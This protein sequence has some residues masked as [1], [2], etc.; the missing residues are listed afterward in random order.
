MTANVLLR[1][2]FIL[3]VKLNAAIYFHTSSYLEIAP[4][5]EAKDFGLTMAYHSNQSLVVGAPYSDRNGKVYTCPINDEVL[6]NRKAMCT[7]I[8][9]DIDKEVPDHS[10]S[11]RHEQSY[12]LGASIAVTPDYIFTCA[13]LLT[14][15]IKT[16]DGPLF[17]PFGTCFIFNGT[18]TSRYSSDKRLL[19]GTVGWRTLA[20]VDNRLILIAKQNGP[21]SDIHYIFMDKPSEGVKIVQETTTSDNRKQYNSFINKGTAFA[22][23]NFI[24][25]YPKL[26]AFSAAE[27]KNYQ[28]LIAFLWYNVAAKKLEL[29]KSDQRDIALILHDKVDA[30]FGSSLH[31][32]NVNADNYTDLLVGAPAHV[33]NTGGYENGAIYIYLGGETHVKSHLILTKLCIYSTKDGSRFG[34]SIATT[35][36][37]GDSYP[38]IFVSAPFEDNGKGTVYIISGHTVHNLLK[39][40]ETEVHLTELVYTQKIQNSNLQSLGYSLQPL[41]VPQFDEYG[42]YFLA[43][44]TLLSGKVALYRSI[45]VITVEVKAS[46]KGTRVREQDNNF[47]M[48]VTIEIT[49]PSEIKVMTGKI[50]LSTSIDGDAAWIENGADHD[51]LLSELTPFNATSAVSTT[52]IFVS[53]GHNRKGLYIFT[54]SVRSDTDNLQRSDFDFSLVDISPRSTKTA[55][56]NLMRECKETLEECIPKLSLK[57]EWLG[58]NETHYTVGSSDIETMT[59]AIRNEGNA[60]FGSCAR[61][62]VTG[63]QIAFLEADMEKDGW[64]KCDLIDIKRNT[65]FRIP[66]RLDMSKPT[67]KEGGLLIKVVLHNTCTSNLNASHY[68]NSIA[69]EF[70]TD[71]IHFNS[72]HFKHVITDREIEDVEASHNIEINELYTI[73]NTA[74]MS[75]S[76]LPLDIY[77][78]AEPFIA[79]FLIQVDSGD[80]QK[81]ELNLKYNCTVDLKP[82][83][84]MT[85]KSTVIMF[86]HNIMDSL[87]ND[88]LKIVSHLKMDMVPSL[89]TLENMYMTEILYEK[90]IGLENNM[91]I[92]LAISILVGIFVM[93]IIAIFL[94]KG[95]FFKRAEKQ[96]L[97]MLKH[98]IRKQS[99][100]RGP[101]IG[102]D[103]QVIVEP[104]PEQLDEDG[105]LAA[106]ASEN[107]INPPGVVGV[108]Q[109]KNVPT[110]KQERSNSSSGSD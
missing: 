44:G 48:S 71:E 46:L 29:L 84:T 33:N 3:L 31:S 66:I 109:R 60:T 35:D 64:Y 110:A 90:T 93:A 95:G 104:N 5:D 14:Q 22:A 102:C 75:W 43:I 78:E 55:T 81:G 12:G 73:T 2:Q 15:E 62:K 6:K 21:L 76:S 70:I 18:S 51:I 80:C 87:K 25:G 26:Y 34:T 19:N 103:P 17:E 11:Q 24:K 106:N 36:L 68:R 92:V 4:P 10:R 83:S 58:S 86:K 39:N 1:F 45:P 47:T 7:Q 101:T 42:Q 74:N 20:D 96:K 91:Y 100:R 28:G 38:E 32:A 9:I 67:N 89:K 108:T 72:T 54:A 63:A 57:F 52:D 82:D 30:M 49:Y 79:D 94:S 27:T 56:V 98:E 61:I 40:G 53:L 85:V 50:L 59:L 65:E 97:D 16:E 105:G 107:E 23:G 41:P 77:L 8:P 37:D 69:Y 13:P 88:T 99:I